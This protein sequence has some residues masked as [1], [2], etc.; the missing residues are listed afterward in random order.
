LFQRIAR[1][2]ARDGRMLRKTRAAPARSAIGDYFIVNASNAIIAHH[3]DIE[4][5]GREVGALK[6]YEHL[7]EN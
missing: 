4:Q 6:P 2:L 3:V 7:F 1:A 5:L